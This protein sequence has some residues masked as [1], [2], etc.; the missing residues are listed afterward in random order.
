MA[1]YANAVDYYTRRNVG[2]GT[3]RADKSR[4]LSL[5]SSMQVNV[6]NMDVLIGPA[7]DTATVVFDKE[8]NFS[9]QSTSTGKVRSQ[10]R[11]TNING[12]WLITSEKD[13][14]VYYTR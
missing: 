8:W 6:S 7:G 1:N 12:R 14:E 5:Y 2:V 10:L 3:I 9:G 4:A 13:L 11:F